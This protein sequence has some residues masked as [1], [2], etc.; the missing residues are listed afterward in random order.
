MTTVRILCRSI[1]RPGVFLY[2]L[3]RRIICPLYRMNK[4]LAPCSAVADIGCGHGLFSIYLGL[5]DT[6]R[7]VIGFDLDA[8]RLAIGEKLIR[9]EKN[10]TFV[11]GYFDVRAESLDGACF[12]DVLHHLSYENQVQAISK[13]YDSLKPGGI[14]LVKEICRGGGIR[15]LLSSLSDAYLYPQD[16]I[17]FRSRQQWLQCLQEAGFSVS[18]RPVRLSPLSTH[19]FVARKTAQ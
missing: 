2:M 1:R 15:F 3:L 9:G 4:I 8:R 11:R 16:T 17:C 18:Y 13:V 7:T 12:S 19:L 10:I 6:K 14:L 5:A